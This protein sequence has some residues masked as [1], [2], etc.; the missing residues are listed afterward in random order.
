MKNPFA[1]HMEILPAAQKGLWPLLRPTVQAGMVLY[2]GT[3]VA[4]RLGHRVS[5]DFDF[6]TEKHLDKDALRRELPF[7][8]TSTVLQ[9]RPDTLTVLV[10]DTVDATPVKVSFF[11]GINCGRVGDPEITPDGTVMVA[12]CAD[13]LAT[14]LKVIL[15][16]IEA[17]DYRDIAAMLAAGASLAQGLADARVLYGPAFQP[18]EA[19]KALV[20]FEGGDLDALTGEEKE[21]L[22][23]KAAMVDELPPARRV[24][25]SVV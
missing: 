16:R 13:L 24:E 22:I 7:I 5:V 23:K 4:L 19:L 10:T 15:Q 17:K 11:G 14:K 9:E 3:A 21:L 18:S 20:F 6:F 1:P 25:G 12:S 8:A 2:G